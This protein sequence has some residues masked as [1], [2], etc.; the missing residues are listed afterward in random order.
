M[1]KR[2]ENICH[3]CGKR[4][5]KEPQQNDVVYLTTLNNGPLSGMFEDMLNNNNIPYMRKEPKGSIPMAVFAKAFSFDY[6]VP[7]GTLELAKEILALVPKQSKPIPAFP[8]I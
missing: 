8:I 6:F 3:L 1:L 5:L 7:Y 2:D 4:K